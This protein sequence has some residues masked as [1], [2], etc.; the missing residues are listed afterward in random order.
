MIPL[1]LLNIVYNVLILQHL[2]HPLRLILWLNVVYLDECFICTWKEHVFCSCWVQCSI[3]SIRSLLSQVPQDT[4][5]AGMI[6]KQK[7]Y[8]RV[9]PWLTAVC[10]REKHTW[11]EGGVELENSF[12]RGLSWSYWE[13]GFE[14]SLQISSFSSHSISLY[15]ATCQSNKTAAFCFLLSREEPHQCESHLAGAAPFFQGLNPLQIP[16]TFCFSPGTS[17]RF[18]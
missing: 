15:S 18:F 14:A 10:K 8:W 1:W 7:V 13:H 4:D 12:H 2:W 9:S 17:N 3:T 5:S 16:P 11:A 6:W